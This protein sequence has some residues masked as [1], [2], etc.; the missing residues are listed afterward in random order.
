MYPSD[1]QRGKAAETLA[2]ALGKDTDL[3]VSKLE[4]FKE[5]MYK[6]LDADVTV[7]STTDR[8]VLGA[9]EKARID[10]TFVDKITVWFDGMENI[11]V[12]R[13]ATGEWET[14]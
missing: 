13:D 14:L 9:L 1:N 11:R 12:Y 5:V 2:D 4:R 10:D 8:I 6:S 7:F 3:P